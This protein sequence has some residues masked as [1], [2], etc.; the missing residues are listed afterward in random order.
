[1]A[2]F[3]NRAT[4]S[5]NG[6]STV[7][8]TVTGTVNETLAVGKNVLADTYTDGSRLTYV[9]S[10]VNSGTQ[11][12]TATVS[13]NLGAYAFG[14]LTLY[15]LTYVVGSATYYVNGV[16]AATPTITSTQPLTF[17]DVTIP[18]GGNAVLIYEADANEYAPLATDSTITNTVT[19][20]G[21]GT[22]ALSAEATVNTVDAPM[23]T[24]TKA[25]CPTSVSTGGTVNY[26]FT[27]LNT[28]NTPAVATDNVTV[29]DTFDPILT[30]TSVTLN[31]APLTSPTDYT[32][33]A[34]TGEFA[35]TPGVITVPAATYTQN[36]DG[37]FT[38]I[39]GEA[40]LS[41]SGTIA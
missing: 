22:E 37:S 25:L 16:L 36:P 5:Y 8:N 10:L 34:A 41:I 32:Y 12:A 9:V 33:N 30:L 13:D 27:I 14:A 15:P 24:I 4:L 1:M 35:T 20:T 17:T 18:A 7:S 29:T 11:P 39:P 6:I 2:T 19:V 23:L 28:G 31:G 38:T 26:T 21:V 40:V 3:T